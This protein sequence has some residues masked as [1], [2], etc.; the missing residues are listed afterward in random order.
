MKH[1]YKKKDRDLISFLCEGN[2]SREFNEYY[3]TSYP[4]KSD[5][6][7]CAIIRYREYMS[8]GDLK[9]MEEIALRFKLKP[10]D[11]L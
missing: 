7:K 8:V 3:A 5:C 6:R 10:R 1:L 11:I 4:L 2:K 9:R